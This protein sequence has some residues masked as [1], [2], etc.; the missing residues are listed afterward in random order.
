[1]GSD[2]VRLGKDGPLVA[3]VG[4]GMWQA[5]GKS[6]GADVSD[7]KCVA[8]MVRAQELGLNLIDTAEAYGEGHSEEVVGRA[9][10]KMDK[11]ETVVATKVIGGHLRYDD[12]I[13]ACEGSL[14]RLG[15]RTIDLYQV[16]WPDPWDQ[17]PL[18][19]TM[20]A[21]EKLQRDGKIHHIGVSNF[22]VRDLKE[23]AEHLSRSTI[24]SNQV[25]YSLVHRAVEDEVLPYCKREG[26]GIIPWSPL[27]KGLVTGKYSMK[28]LPKDPIR[29]EMGFFTLHNMRE[30]APLVGLLKSIGKRYRK[31]PAQVALQWLVA[32]GTVPIPGVKTPEQVDENAGSVGWRLR[33]EE[34]AQI[35]NTAEAMKIDFF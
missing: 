13:R 2:R 5:S 29:K 3:P 7:T 24:V 31:T 12:V 22:A 16:H 33:S 17:V 15:I 26:I 1:M 6:W 20:R 28:R 4:V 21:L 10:R 11:D 32:Q 30:V 9:L 23:A 18:K 27:A 35:R 8:A 19:H 34:V 14:K 25:Q